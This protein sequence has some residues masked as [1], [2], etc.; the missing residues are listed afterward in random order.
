MSCFERFDALVRRPLAAS[1]LLA[2]VFVYRL[3]FGLCSEF[4]FI[5][6]KQ[7]YLIGL[8][9]FTTGTWPYFGPDLVLKDHARIYQIPGALQGLLVGL[10][11]YVLP[12][13]EAPFLLLNLLS[14]AALVFLAWYG[15]RRVPSLPRW[16]VF[17]L[18]LTLPWTLHYSTHV[19][20]PSYLLSGSVVFFIGAMEALVFPETPLLPKRLSD[21]AMGFGLL[22]VLQLHMSWALLVP[23]AAAALVARSIRRE[24]F[25]ALAAF[26]AGAAV[27]GSMLLPTLTAYDLRSA[28]NAEI[29]IRF[30]PTNARTLVGMV[31]KELSFASYELPRFIAPSYRERREWILSDGRVT[32]FALLAVAVGIVQPIM[33][34]AFLFRRREGA[35]GWRRMKWFLIATLILTWLAFLFT[36]REPWALT[37]YL[38]FPVPFVY[39]LYCYAFFLKGKRW[40]GFAALVLLAGLVTNTALAARNYRDRS[41]YRDRDLVVK[42][43][44][45]RDYRILG[46]RREGTFY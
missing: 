11:F 20:N 22:W 40:L 6:E 19:V 32:P 1:L 29:A 12:I 25:Q 35:P 27:T 7:I 36:V 34:L 45:Q 5:D 28:G 17:G 43:L 14:F 23:F 42:A 38:A 21:A 16:L 24:G 15:C 9:F 37:Y 46:T 31:A 18:A 44:A 26:V 10:P 13:P 33:M 41:L 4:W 39:S 8:K 2:L 30:N 3:V